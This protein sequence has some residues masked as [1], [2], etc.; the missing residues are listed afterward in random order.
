MVVVEGKRTLA[1]CSAMLVQKVSSSAIRDGRKLLGL[2][3][4][5]AGVLWSVNSRKHGLQSD[6]ARQRRS[7]QVTRWL[8]GM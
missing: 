3:Y 5:K 1:F 4:S 2:G 6:P 7:Q 8:G